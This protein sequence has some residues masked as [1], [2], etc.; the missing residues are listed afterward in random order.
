MR[1]KFKL[2]VTNPFFSGSAL[3]F[4]GSNA[5]NAINYVYHLIMGR[6]L[7]PSSY[8]ELAALFS[9]IG[10]LGIFTSSLGLVVVKYISAAR[11]KEEITDLAGW[12]NRKTI[13]F[14]I[15]F[16]I[17]ILIFSPAI[18]N[19]LKIESPILIVL[20]AVTIILGY[21]SFF[22]RSILQGLLKFREV[23]I[24]VLLENSTKLILGVLLVYVGFSVF[25]AM[26]GV[27][28][29]GL[30]GWGLSLYFIR[31]YLGKEVKR[32][33]NFKSM[34]KFS[35]PVFIYSMATTSLYSTDLV[36]VKH[37]LTSHDAG[38]YAALSTLGKIIFF[39]AAPISS[40]MFPM[41]SKRQT[42]G[43]SFR[44]VFFYSL[45]LTLMISTAVLLL[46]WFF[47]KWA[48][49]ILYG[50]LYLGAS[51]L[52]VKFGIFMTLFTL[53]VL[54][55]NLYLSL[56]DVKVV[57]LPLV[58]AGLQIIGLWFYHSNL[59]AVILVSILITAL[60]LGSLFIYFL[61]YFRYEIRYAIKTGL[62]HSARLQTRENNRQR[63]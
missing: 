60:L 38:L 25:G 30:I 34:L 29:A 44:R 13:F 50:S 40:V 5:T 35:I 17:L 20:I 2:L 24:G 19:F 10:L 8:G 6:L 3:M 51:P 37:F 1:A 36:L 61:I 18:S 7:G 46:Y 22:N 14:S 9:L 59:E 26:I 45:A 58:A 57:L 4:F 32:P 27:L 49:Q 62:S 33:P 63:S 11:T 52:L 31:E 28:A 43:E 42:S 21:P 12:I 47:P 39:A 53:S 23:V 41:I 48:I 54:L 56:G 16:A 15:S 55:I